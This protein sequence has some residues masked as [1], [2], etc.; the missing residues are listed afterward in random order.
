MEDEVHMMYECEA[1]KGER[2][3]FK[4]EAMSIV[5][6]SQFD[7][8][9]FLHRMLQSDMLKLTA[10]HLIVMMERRREIMYRV[11]NEGQLTQP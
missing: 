2:E 6:L 7:G 10:K 5:D 9:N 1:L 3:L 8:I 4:Q 11:E